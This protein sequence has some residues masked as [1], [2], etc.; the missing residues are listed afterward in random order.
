MRH[1]ICEAEHRPTLPVNL[2]TELVSLVGRGWS[3]DPNSRPHAAQMVAVID[4][5][6]ADCD[7][8]AQLNASFEVKTTQTAA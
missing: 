4:R 3:V 1:A 2:P 7:T 5:L 8:Q 6:I